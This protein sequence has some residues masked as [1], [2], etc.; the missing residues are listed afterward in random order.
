MKTQYAIY[1]LL[2]L[3]LSSLGCSK[4]WEIR[5]DDD[6]VKGCADF[7][8]YKRIGDDMLLRFWIDQHKIAFSRNFQ[9][10]EDISLE[11]FASVELDQSCNVASLWYTACNDVGQN[12]GCPTTEWKL[13]K[14]GLSFKVNKVLQEYHCNEPYT[15]TVILFNATFVKEGTT[16]S[17]TFDMIELKNVIVGHCAG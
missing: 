1:A 13:Q 9:T 6:T 7:I 12:P 15:A 2:F 8:I 3:A 17:R 5:D 14:G 10:F 4:S 16:E 11:N